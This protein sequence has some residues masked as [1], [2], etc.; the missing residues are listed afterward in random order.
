MA[1]EPK[2]ESE[3][4][5][6]TVATETKEPEKLHQGVDIKD[7]GP[8]K[9]HV[10]VTIERGDIDKVLEKKF[11]ELVHEAPVAGFRPGKAPRK[12]VER[13][14]EKEVRNQVRGE[15]LLQSL[16]QLVED[17]DLAPLTAPNIDPESIFIPD[18]GPLVYEFDV[19]VRPEFELPNYKGL[20]LKREVRTFAEADVDEAV[21]R[22]LTPYGSLVPK[23]KGKAE[24]GDYLVSDMTTRDGDRVLSTHKEIT[25][26]IDKRLVLKDG[27]AKEFAQ[28]VVGASP[29]DKKTFTIDL[30]DTVA[31][32]ELRNK[33]VQAELDIKEIK[34]LR[35]PEL[36]TEFLESL[37][38]TTEEM[39]RER[40]RALLERRHQY[41]QRQSGRTQI[42]EKLM[43]SINVQLPQ[44][45]VQ[46]HARKALQRRLIDMQ[47]A[48]MSE[49]EITARYRMLQRDTYDHTEAELREHFILQKI[50][51]LEKI[52]IN[53]EDIEDEIERI[54]QQN[55]ESPRRVRARLE[56]GDLMEA[57]AT[58]V[59]E[60][61]ALDLVLDSAEYEEVPYRKVDEP[62]TGTVEQQAVPG[63]IHEIGEE[64]EK[65]EEAEGGSET[66][67]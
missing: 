20:Q 41:E 31:A 49:Q 34:S 39:L 52:E 40:V 17:T 64:T 12:L 7:A 30:L 27:Y 46:R 25:L 47:Q 51:D 56:K 43:G 61:K 5:E 15:L 63:E 2:P 45:L 14:F 13:R 57:L 36:T 3:S 42:L 19:E 60:Q 55:D 26:R 54:A 37:G 24:E 38:A 10:K 58:Q 53:E 48:G 29:G 9:K 66:K 21:K 1:E 4:G 44:D 50:A 62:S 8:C 16:E 18:E 32:P 11:S 23:T 33:S 67:S 35:L 59:V 65:T 22:V 6:A 28:S